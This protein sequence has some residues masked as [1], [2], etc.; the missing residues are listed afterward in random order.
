MGKEGPK[1]KSRR[2]ITYDND[3]S[4]DSNDLELVEIEPQGNSFVDQFNMKPN[5]RF[6]NYKEIFENLSKSKSVAT[7]DP[8]ITV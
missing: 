5:S 6:K 8:I 2:E 1:A 3:N 4:V 7:T